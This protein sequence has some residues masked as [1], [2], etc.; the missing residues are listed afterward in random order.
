MPLCLL[1]NL[2]TAKALGLTIPPGVLWHI[3]DIATSWMDFRFRGKNGHA[4]DITGMTEFVKVFGC[5][6]L[7]N[8]SAGTEGRRPKTSKG[9]NRAEGRWADAAS[10]MG[11]SFSFCAICS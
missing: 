7:T 5:R 2:K 1:L 3:R 4:A 10:A 9:G 11:M 6:P 8:G